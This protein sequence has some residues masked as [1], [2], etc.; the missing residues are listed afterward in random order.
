LA[1]FHDSFSKFAFFV[2][3]LV[4]TS[5]STAGYAYM[6]SAMVELQELAT[7]YLAFLFVIMAVIDVFT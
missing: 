7:L 5:M 1:D 6:F 4:L 2:L 3:V